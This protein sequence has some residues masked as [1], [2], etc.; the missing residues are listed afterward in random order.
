MALSWVDAFPEEDEPVQAARLLVDCWNQLVAFP[1]TAF[2]GKWSEPKLTSFLCEHLKNVSSSEGRLTG[3]WGQENPFA[4]INAA[5]GKVDKS[6][7]TDIEYFS[8]RAPRVLRLIFE[9]KKIDHKQRNIT[10]YCGTQGMRRFID[11][12]YASGEPVAFM[13]GIITADKPKCL[14][15][16]HKTLQKKEN[17]TGFQWRGGKAATV[18]PSPAFPGLS[19]FDTEHLRPVEKLPKEGFVRICHVFL[20]F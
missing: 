7:R 17:A 18:T 15:K 20:E 14:A 12:E 6:F 3:R 2:T 8:N 19:E 11:G 10:H 1:A 9:F 13:A 16:L 5:S 4:K